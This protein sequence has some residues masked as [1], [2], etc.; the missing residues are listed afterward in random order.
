MI[1]K[2]ISL[3]FITLISQIINAQIASEKKPSEDPEKL[4]KEAV[5]FLRETIADV[6]NLRTLENRISFAAEIAGL[7]WFQNEKEARAMFAAAIGDFK[8]LLLQYDTE[9]NALG[10]ASDDEGGSGGFMA[11]MT[12]PTDRNQLMRKFQTAMAVRQQIAGSLAEHDGEMAFTFYQDS[13]QV[14]NLEFR[15]QMEN[16]DDYFEHQLM[17]RIAEKNPGRAAQFG[18]KSLDKGVGYNHIELLKKI[19]AKAPIKAPILRRRFC[20]RSKAANRTRAIFTC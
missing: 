6:N 2:L 19:Y 3:V 12:E 20:P 11:M 1:H 4:K 14:S 15:T 17:S 10:M 7:M 9:M 5:V 16:R 13:S 18:A 8:E